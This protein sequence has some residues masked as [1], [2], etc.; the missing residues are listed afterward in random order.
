MSDFFGAIVGVGNKKKE[1]RNKNDFYP[2]PGLVIQC[3]NEYS[4]IPD[5]IWEPAAGRGHIAKELKKLGKNV[6]AS[7]LFEYDNCLHDIQTGINFLNSVTPHG[8]NSI[9]TNPP[10]I[11]DMAEKFVLS[12]IERKDIEYSAFFCRMQFANSKRRYKNLFSKFPPS[13]ILCFHSRINCNEE[14]A[15]SDDYNDHTGGMLE[16]YWYIWDKRNNY[17]STKFT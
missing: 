9:I 7:D 11:N 12:A 5:N 6:Y 14:S 16:Y 2:T 1:D 13:E 10:Y 3:L 15:N 8:Y 17:T 4:K